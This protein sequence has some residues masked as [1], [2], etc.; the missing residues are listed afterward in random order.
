MDLLPLPSGLVIEDVQRRL[1]MFLAQ[2][3]PY[4]DALADDTPNRVTPLDVLA[5]VSVNAYAFSGGAGN[6]R[7]IHRGLAAACDPLLPAIPVEARLSDTET[8]LDALRELLHAAV[9]VPRVP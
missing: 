6:L 2:E 8:D 9:S 1:D 5:P 7:L 4:Y 3:W